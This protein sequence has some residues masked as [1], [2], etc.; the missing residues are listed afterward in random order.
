M[1]RKRKERWMEEKR[2]GWIEEMR[3]KV[4]RE[5][6]ELE[7]LIRSWGGGGGKNTSANSTSYPSSSVSRSNHQHQPRIQ[8][9]SSAFVTTGQASTS[10]TLSGAETEAKEKEERMNRNL[11]RAHSTSSFPSSSR[12][13]SINPNGPPS[14]LFLRSSGLSLSPTSPGSPTSPIS[15]SSTYRSSVVPIGFVFNSGNGAGRDTARGRE[16]RT[17]S[18]GDLLSSMSMPT[19]LDSDQDRPC[20]FSSSS[21]HSS[22]CSSSY[23][24]Y[25]CSYGY[26]SHPDPDPNS[27]PD[28]PNTSAYAQQNRY[29]KRLTMDTVEP[30]KLRVMGEEEIGR[31]V[32]EGLKRMRTKMGIGMRVELKKAPLS[33]GKGL[34]EPKRGRGEGEGD[35]DQS[36]AASEEI[37]VLGSN[38]DS[39]SN[40]SELSS[41]GTLVDL[42]TPTTVGVTTV[43]GIAGMMTISGEMKERSLLEMEA[44]GGIAREVGDGDGRL[45]QEGLGRK[46]EVDTGSD[47]DSEEE[48]GK[49]DQVGDV[50]GF[51]GGDNGT[52]TIYRRLAA[53][54][55]SLSEIDIDAAT[56]KLIIDG[57]DI[58]IP[59]YAKELMELLEGT[60]VG[61]GLARTLKGGAAPVNGSS[62][63]RSGSTTLTWR[64]ASRPSGAGT[65][66]RVKSR[67]PSPVP[68]P[69][70]R[71]E[72]SKLESELELE[73]GPGSRSRS[74]TVP[75]SSIVTP[76]NAQTP[77][78]E[79][80]ISRSPILTVPVPADDRSRL[81]GREG[82]AV[83]GSV[84]LLTLSS[85][86]E[87]RDVHNSNSRSREENQHEDVEDTDRS[88][89]R[90]SP[91]NVFL[92]PPSS[93]LVSPN[94]KKRS[95]SRLSMSRISQISTWTPSKKS[96]RSL[97]IH[98]LSPESS[99]SGSD[100]EPEDLPRTRAG[101]QSPTPAPTSNSRSTGSNSRS[102]MTLRKTASVMLSG[103]VSIPKRLS[104]KLSRSVFTGGERGEGERR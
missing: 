1:E 96:L 42:E 64:D 50:F 33:E 90:P 82:G 43:T 9:Q 24:F 52:A 4:E 61:E 16:R 39:N 32:V 91:N 44:Q 47:A 2:L 29:P 86:Y 84:S 20:L 72:L 48:P 17:K 30:M 8:P 77:P 103:S 100:L 68:R 13:S 34:G 27:N 40:S 6:K 93:P 49:E 51:F 78:P 19:N 97:L 59:E 75:S 56:A 79:G 57:E 95:S 60:R 81:V 12:S 69:I 31:E 66:R 62:Y 55:T 28:H 5:M 53:S 58:Q 15:T 63:S 101:E 83:S 85:V 3:G 45:E 94:R 21:Y 14:P 99:P 18:S 92:R 88:E 10:K 37:D 89:D 38:S 26:P 11:A 98:P 65:G 23:S 25:G 71:L 80:K 36:S 54:T 76:I 46:E 41:V 70:A 7:G 87:A 22:S 67:P 35:R 102:P 104:R 73:F 74:L